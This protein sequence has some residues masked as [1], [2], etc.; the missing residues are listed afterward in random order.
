MYCTKPA[1]DISQGLN[2]ALFMEC[3]ILGFNR[4]NLPVGG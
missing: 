2:K 1:I 4:K 3:Q